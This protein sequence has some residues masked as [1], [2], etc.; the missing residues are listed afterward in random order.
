AHDADDWSLR[1]DYPRNGARDI[2]L[3]QPFA[4]WRQKWNRFF[5]I[6]H[7][8]AESQ[9]NSLVVSKQ[10]RLQSIQPCRVLRV[11]I[12]FRVEFLDLYFALCSLAV[13]RKQILD[14]LRIV[15]QRRR[16]LVT[17]ASAVIPYFD[18]RIDLCQ[19]CTCARG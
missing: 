6:K 3:Q 12:R 10:L 8:D 2:V 13:F 19:N 18:W 7:A 11:G 14:A 4:R 17:A 1:I 9:I 15:S 16:H 5:L